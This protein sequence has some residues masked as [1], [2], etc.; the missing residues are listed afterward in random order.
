MRG[1]L[2]P[3]FVLVVLA[4]CAGAAGAGTAGGGGANVITSEQLREIDVEGLSVYEVIQRLRPNWL[5]PRG[6]SISSG[7]SIPRAVVDGVAYG[8][9]SDLS[10]MSAREVQGIEFVSAADATTRFGTGYVGGA[11]VVRTR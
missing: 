7:A 1:A 4:G 3:L 2:T 6:A 9:V 10:S 11:V 8:E 5:R